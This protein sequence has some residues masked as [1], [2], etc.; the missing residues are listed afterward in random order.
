MV[1]DAPPSN[2]DIA[3]VVAAALLHP[4]AYSERQRIWN[5][6]SDLRTSNGRVPLR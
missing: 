4:V 1:R 3:R 2:E 6:A 5:A